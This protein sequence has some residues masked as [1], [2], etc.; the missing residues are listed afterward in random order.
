MQTR[1]LSVRFIVAAVAAMLCSLF[2]VSGA[3]AQA[4]VGGTNYCSRS[5]RVSRCLPPTSRDAKWAELKIVLLGGKGE[6]AQAMALSLLFAPKNG[7]YLSAFGGS[8]DSAR[9][10]VIAARS[11]STCRTALKLGGAW[12][13]YDL[14]VK[15]KKE[16]EGNLLGK[17]ML[18]IAARGVPGSAGATAKALTSDLYGQAVIKTGLSKMLEF[19]GPTAA[20]QTTLREGI[21]VAFHMA[22]R[23]LAVN[24]WA[25]VMKTCSVGV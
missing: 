22:H 21:K 18:A 16:A 8:Y 19:A 25:N 11:N 3:P 6:A 2:M 5:E 1:Q 9:R 23:G 13:A 20:W 12:M 7:D 10:A 14:E 4:A 17:I 15:A 24:H